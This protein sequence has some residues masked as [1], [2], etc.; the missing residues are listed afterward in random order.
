MN[1]VGCLYENKTGDEKTICLSCARWFGDESFK[2]RYVTLE[3][4]QDNIREKILDAAKEQVNGSRQQ[5]YGTPEDNFQTIADLW[6]AYKSGYKFSSEDVAVMMMM[7]K[8]ARIASGN[9]KTDNYIDLAGYAACAGEI[10]ER[11]SR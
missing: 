8:I 9:Y 2:D 5:D 7:V 4:K 3:T 10:A 11:K 1:C 6:M